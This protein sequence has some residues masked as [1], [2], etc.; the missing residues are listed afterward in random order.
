VPLDTGVTAVKIG[1]TRT[2]RNE[3]VAVS[4]CLGSQSPAIAG[5]LI[6]SCS[7]SEWNANGKA[8]DEMNQWLRSRLAPGDLEEYKQ[9]KPAGILADARPMPRWIHT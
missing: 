4:G 6:S 1:V 8:G 7:I 3:W 9:L 5:Y 2:L